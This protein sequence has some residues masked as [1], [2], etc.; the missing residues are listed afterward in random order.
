MFPTKK[1]DNEARRAEHA[2]RHLEVVESAH[3]YD[4]MSGAISWC[5]ADYNTHVEFGSGDRICYHGVLD[6][7]RIPKYAAAVYASQQSKRPILVVASNMVMGEYPASALPPTTVYTNCD[8]IKVYKNDEYID[9]YYSA[10]D[11]YPAIPNA[12]VIIDD[13]IANRIHQGESY[14][15]KVADMI[16]TVMLAYVKHGMRLTPKAKI[17]IVK[18]GLVHGVKVKDLMGLFGKYIGDWGTKGSRYRFEGYKDDEKVIEVVRGSSNQAKFVALPDATLLVH[19]DTYDATRILV[20][21]IDEFG[22]DLP[23][24]TAS[25]NITVSE[26]FEVIGPNVQSL[27]GGSIG[28]YV[29]TTGVRGSGTIQLTPD[30]GDPVVVEIEVA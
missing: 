24:A 23:Y 4:S 12:P 22:N 9:T 14:P 19:G 18:L 6:M 20:R 1:F 5:M 25:F 3:R 16:K 13:Y 26:Q 27:I 17:N 8:Y 11:Q 28:V 30:H 10:W 7:F 15:K 2:K 21:M 29:K